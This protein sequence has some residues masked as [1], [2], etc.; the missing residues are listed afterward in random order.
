MKKLEKYEG[1]WKNHVKAGQKKI[2]KTLLP[3]SDGRKGMILCDFDENKFDGFGIIRI[4]S[5]YFKNKYIKYLAIL[6]KEY[7]V[8]SDDE[9]KFIEDDNIGELVPIPTESIELPF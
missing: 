3:T 6:N 8:Y 4:D 5:G 9:G 7:C 1:S 2:I